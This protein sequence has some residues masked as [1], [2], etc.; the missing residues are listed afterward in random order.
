MRT[1]L[2]AHQ[3][4]L[5]QHNAGFDTEDIFGFGRFFFLLQCELADSQ[6]L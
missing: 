6:E 2:G 5:M 3:N 1:S 4:P